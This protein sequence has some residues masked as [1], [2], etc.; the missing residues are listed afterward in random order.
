MAL[1]KCTECNS[2]VSDK[3]SACPKCGV[4]INHSIIEQQR[5]AVTQSHL[6][7]DSFPAFT[8][9]ILIV[10]IVGGVSMGSW[11]V[12]G[13]VLLG[14]ILV[15]MIPVIRKIV[16][17]ALAGV[18][19]YM[20]YMLGTELWGQEAGYVIGGLFFMAS[21]GAS[22]MGIDYIN[23]ISKTGKATPNYNNPTEEDIYSAIKAG[24]KIQAI[25]C[26]KSVHQVSL[27]EA[28]DAIENLASKT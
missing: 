28:K 5:A 17:L 10:A 1:I 9:Q 4:P 22:L 11:L 7:Q 23:D 19:G 13:G 26:Y 3:A 15:F 25:K 18:F 14:L 6:H 27:K 12:F 21:M 16:A 8:F 24:H 20:G 2:E